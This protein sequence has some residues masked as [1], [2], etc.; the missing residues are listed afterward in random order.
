[1]AAFNLGR[2]RF[3][4]KGEW[5][6]STEYVRDDV[7]RYGSSSYV[8]TIP[9]TSSSWGTNSSKF[10][11]MASGAGSDVTTTLGDITYYDGDQ[12]TR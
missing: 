8:C 5:A 11:M 10:E 6:T 12:N 4:W 9:H 1:M 2:L 7:V 3:V